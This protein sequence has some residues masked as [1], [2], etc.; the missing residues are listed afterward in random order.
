MKRFNVIIFMALSPSLLCRESRG[1]KLEEIYD[2]HS[3]GGVRLEDKIYDN[4]GQDGPP[5]L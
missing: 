4:P 2:S 5:Q 1:P 3:Q